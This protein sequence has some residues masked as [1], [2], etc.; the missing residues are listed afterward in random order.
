MTIDEV[1]AHEIERG[2]LTKEGISPGFSPGFVSGDVVYHHEWGRD[3]N[4][5]L[6]CVILAGLGRWYFH[7]LDAKTLTVSPPC[8]AP[9]GLE[10]MDT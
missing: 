1:I 3:K 8:E 6:I 5:H 9:E 2:T 4:G 7:D 10:I